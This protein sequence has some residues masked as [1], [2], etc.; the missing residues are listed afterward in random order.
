MGS[1]GGD[2]WASGWESVITGYPRSCSGEAF[3]GGA[4]GSSTASAPV[5]LEGAAR[6]SLFPLLFPRWSQE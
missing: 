3:G 1:C 6:V 2:R 4:I 5:L